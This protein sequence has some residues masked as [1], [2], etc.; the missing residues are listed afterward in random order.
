MHRIVLAVALIAACKKSNPQG[1]PPATDWGSGS[2][3][4]TAMTPTT[5]PNAPSAPG[6]PA[7]GSGELPPDHPP[8]PGSSPPMPGGH[9][10]AEG[11]KTLTKLDGGR[12]AM[13]PYS[14]TVPPG[15]TEVPTTSN[16]RAAQ[17]SIGT[18][19][20]LIIYYFGP[21]GAG[22]VDD[23]LDRWIN[24]F[25]QPDGK[26][27]KDVAKIEKIKVLGKA[28]TLVSV[29]GTFQGMQMPGGAAPTE[30]SDQSLLGAITDSSSGPYYWK[31]VG[32]KAT[33]AAN[34]GK[35]RALLGSL[36]QN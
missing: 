10:P 29:S 30:K 28:A 33:V 17:F 36:K 7:T 13:G 26:A 31:L 18:D 12:V 16:M 32:K 5:P 3:A 21:E 35:F 11:N 24:Q 20:E 15:W 9:P 19:A 14:F 1:L 4:P 6:M 2:G 27:S 22:S 8:V 25:T 34:A 23:N